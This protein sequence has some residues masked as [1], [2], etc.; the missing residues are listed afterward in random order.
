MLAKLEEMVIQNIYDDAD[1]F[2]EYK[3][4][5]AKSV[6][7]N[8]IM[9]QPNLWSLLPDLK[10][11]RVLDL[12][13]GAGDTCM[14]CIRRGAGHVMGIDVSNNMIEE[15]EAHNSHNLI[16]YNVDSIEE[17]EYPVS[18]YDCV[19]SSLAFHYIEDFGNTIEK[20]SLALT[21]QGVLVFSQE[22]PVITSTKE[23]AHW[24]R[25]NDEK[26]LHWKLDNYFDEGERAVDWIVKGVRKYHRSLQSITA[27][28]I[29]SEFIIQRIL[30]PTVTVEFAGRYPN[31]MDERR[32]PLM[33]MIKC[34]KAA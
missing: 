24:F 29:D 19:V 27:A 11:K 3:R 25:D 30:E 12:G 22:H 5:R 28:L 32:I 10:G 18:A 7:A 23:R 4:I 8:V 17:Y 34:I 15:A 16:T 33:L 14:E 13:C 31:F 26:K 21:K 2:E 9:E 1:F 20:I 6:N